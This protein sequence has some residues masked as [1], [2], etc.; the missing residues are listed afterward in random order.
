MPSTYSKDLNQT[1]R[2]PVRGA[3]RDQVP[4]ASIIRDM[5]IRVAPAQHDAALQPW[6]SVFA[7]ARERLALAGKTW[8]NERDTEGRRPTSSIP[9]AIDR[10]Q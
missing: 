5:L 8:R 1:A 10:N 9:S 4:R 3:G 2:A 6:K 7:T